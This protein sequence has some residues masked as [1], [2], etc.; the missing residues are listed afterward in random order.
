MLGG[1][2]GEVE[3]GSAGRGSIGSRTGAVLSTV[4]GN[5]MQNMTPRPSKPLGILSSVGR[6]SDRRLGVDAGVGIGVQF[7][8]QA[9]SLDSDPDSVLRPQVSTQTQKSRKSAP[10]SAENVVAEAQQA[11]IGHETG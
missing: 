2:L 1:A 6:A 7:L 4:P 11:R 3:G 9:Q 5:A 8:V 10:I